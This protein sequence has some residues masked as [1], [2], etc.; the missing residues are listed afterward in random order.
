MARIHRSDL[1]EVLEDYPTSKAVIRQAAL[2]LAVSRVMIII[3][4]YTAVATQSLQREEQEN[5]RREASRR[6]SS[7]RAGSPQAGSSS[8]SEEDSF[9]VDPTQSF[10]VRAVR[11]SM[12]AIT[13]GATTKVPSPTTVLQFIF[14]NLL[15]DWREVEHV[16]DD[17]VIVEPNADDE[18]TKL[19]AM[20][21]KYDVDMSGYLDVDE[22]MT[23]INE[24]GLAIDEKD[25][26]DVL[27]KYDED[28][29][30]RIEF[31]E[32]IKVVK[33]LRRFAVIGQGVGL[34]GGS[35]GGSKNNSPEG[36]RASESQEGQVLSGSQLEA[37]LGRL[38][39]I[40]AKLG[41]A[42]HVASSGPEGSRTVL[43]SA[44][45]V[46]DGAKNGGGGSIS[47]GV[48]E[49]LK[50]LDD[51]VDGMAASVRQSNEMLARL[52]S[53]VAGLASL[54]KA[55][56]GA[57]ALPKPNVTRNARQRESLA[58]RKEKLA[59]RAA[60]SAEKLA[61]ATAV[62]P[63]LPGRRAAVPPPLPSMSPPTVATPSPMLP[64]SVLSS[65]LRGEEG[66]C[67]AGTDTSPTDTEH[68]SLAATPHESPVIPPPPPP[69]APP[70]HPPP[71]PPPP[72]PPQP[73][74]QPPPAPP[75]PP[76]PPPAPPPPSSTVHAESL[77]PAGAEANL[78]T[79]G[80]DED[81]ELDAAESLPVKDVP[82]RARGPGRSPRDGSLDA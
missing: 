82:S 4:L 41:S 67:V 34:N 1:Y 74:P 69:H 16:G 55:G 26:Q 64:H 46:S 51:R 6:S 42:G 43:S 33:E 20:F 45:V 53:E 5:A 70:S 76:P 30:G 61:R 10:A 68:R 81:F 79:T 31:R 75:P 13:G 24:M 38:D 44:G 77:A 23:C 21:R 60:A 2:K 37:V 54:L 78:R 17:L 49:H 48:R 62:P 65:R 57:G 25:A 18:I 40:D 28:K 11:K 39:A 56:A 22:V 58:V 12:I 47:D 7:R 35:R 14:G 8:L 15:N 63:P 29:T 19:V 3:S 32:F 36:Q 27:Y 52:S 50:A 66:G 9:Y 71:P 72:P 59:S 80:H 73:Q